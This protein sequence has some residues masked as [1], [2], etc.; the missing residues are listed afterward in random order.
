MTCGTRRSS[1]SSTSTLTRSGVSPT[2]TGAKTLSRRT[3][4]DAIN[5]HARLAAAG[6]DEIAELPGPRWC[7]DPQEGPSVDLRRVL[8]NGDHTCGVMSPGDRPPKIQSLPGPERDCRSDQKG[9]NSQVLTTCGRRRVSEHRLASS[10]AS[11]QR[12]SRSASGGGVTRR[13]TRGLSGG[14]GP[15]PSP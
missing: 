15:R 14:V 2:P 6:H 1:W 12:S 9:R 10:G 8:W 7:V 4:V 11:D 13:G 5:L 3:D